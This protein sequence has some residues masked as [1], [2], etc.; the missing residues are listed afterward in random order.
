[1]L[2]VFALACDP[3]ATDTGDKSPVDTND[4][5]PE[6]GNDR[7]GD[8]VPDDADCDPD[9]ANVYPGHSE[10]PYNGRDDDCDGFDESD[11]DDDG[12]DGDSL[13]GGTD[14]DDNSAT[15]H[16]GAVEI[17]YNSIDDN[18]DGWEGG[19]D[20]DGD[21]YPLGSDCD[22][23]DASAFPGAPD[24]WYDG[25][26]SDCAGNDDFDQDVDGEQS[27]EY[28]GTDCT[29]TDEGVFAGQDESWNGIDDDCDGTIDIL[30]TQRYFGK[31][32]GDSGAGEETFGQAF[33]VVPDLDGDGRRDLWIGAPGSAELAGRVWAIGSGEGIVSS[34]SEGLG[35][36]WGAEATGMGTA[37]S[38]TT[39]NGWDQLVVGAPA[40]GAP[41]GVAY[42]VETD[43]FLGG[44]LPVVE[45]SVVS[46]VTFS[47]AGGFLGDRDG[48]L[49]V[50]CSS[51]AINTMVAAYT[52]VPGG[53]VGA[54]DAHFFTESQARLC[55]ITEFLGDLDGDGGNEL[56][57]VSAD[58]T[59]SAALALVQS[60]VVDLGGAYAL[61]DL[62]QY[63]AVGT[64]T[65]LASLDD[66]DGDGLSEA[67]LSYSTADGAAV[68]DGRA[69]VVGG[70]AFV[71]GTDVL[72]TATSTISG[73]TDAAGLR[74]GN[75]GDLD[76][77][78]SQEL[79]IG[80]PGLGQVGSIPLATLAT[81]G[82]HLPA[83]RT[84][85]FISSS[86]DEFGSGLWADDLDGDGDDDMIATRAYYP[87][88][89][90]WF[91]RE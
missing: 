60:S 38:A 20:C 66:M 69:Y 68:G 83:E 84:P 14:C 34:A 53:S 62:D 59:G 91:L 54:E 18:C 23:E 7:D 46:S 16:P 87:G 39:V 74:P 76:A 80:L 36:L 43:G 21:G 58:G 77:D 63:P 32:S 11:F 81:P 40:A 50:G 73:G 35:Y 70:A 42:L 17:C 29:D 1:M 2:L 71:S 49:V 33:A 48:R 22:E 31:V 88:G 4:T 67:L 86:A 3:A 52:T 65:H 6:V 55:L 8:G 5:A 82:D 90:L 75:V 85:W 10:V 78:G 9:N 30:T 28:G 41:V 12:Y 64:P 45:E 26:D 51:G 57:I 15:V 72:A 79:L 25:I 13:E 56:A 27:A 37:V 24:A 61:A 44:G 19:N 89:V 47:G